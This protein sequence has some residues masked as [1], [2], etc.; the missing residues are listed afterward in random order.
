MV[1]GP[2]DDRTLLLLDRLA[3]P[4]VHHAHRDAAALH[5]HTEHLHRRVRGQEDLALVR[6]LRHPQ[7][8]CVTA[9]CRD[10]EV[11]EELTAK[12]LGDT[13]VEAGAGELRN[14]DDV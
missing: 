14:S 13:T 12:A 3:L 6:E 5:I 4:A 9:P 1:R 10:A 2:Q 11:D 8:T 7:R